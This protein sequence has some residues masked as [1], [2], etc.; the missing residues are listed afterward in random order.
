VPAGA[1][2]RAAGAGVRAAGRARVSDLPLPLLARGKVRELYEVD[3][4]HLLLV[5]SDRLSAYDVVLPTP[6]RQGSGAHGTVGVVV[7]P[8][9]RRRAEPPGDRTGR[10]LPRGAAAA[11]RRA[12][13]TLDAVPPAGDAAGRVRGPRLPTGSGLSDYR[14]RVRSAAVA[15]PPGLV[16]GSQLP[17]RSS[18]PPPRP[19][20]A[21]TTRTCRTTRSSPAVGSGPGAPAALA[22]RWPS[23]ARGRRWPPSADPARRHQARVRASRRRQL[24]LGDEVLTPDSSRF[25]PADGWEPG[26]RSRRTT[27]SSCATG[28]RHPGGTGRRPGRSCPRRWWSRRGA[29]RGGYERLTGSSFDSW[30][31]ES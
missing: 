2:P 27:S 4:E 22:R 1:L 28:C 23:T 6:S 30:L 18:R 21:T 24:V 3:R 20:S 15:L 10:R 25:W 12:A 26:A 11:R 29:L 9:R 7:R 14:S 31:R 13:R 16:D 19:P 8:A 5:A 17:S